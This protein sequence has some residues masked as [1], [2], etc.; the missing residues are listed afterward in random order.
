MPPLSSSDRVRDDRLAPGASPDRRPPST[1]RRDSLRGNQHCGQSNRRARL[2]DIHRLLLDL[3]LEPMTDSDSSDQHLIDAHPDLMPELAE[4]LRKH[5]SIRAALARADEV[6][7]RQALDRLRGDDR[8]H[9]RGVSATDAPASGVT[10]PP[11]RPLPL[12]IG[13]YLLVERIGEGGFATVYRARDSELRR[14]VA[15]KIP[16][17]DRASDPDELAGYLAEARMAA[18]LDHPSIVPVFD[19]G[20]M[21]GGGCYVVSK[22]IPGTDLAARLSKDQLAMEQ[23][24]SIVAEIAEALS[25][26]HA[27]GLIHRD[28]KPA[29]ILLDEQD[30]PFLADFGLALQQRDV[31]EQRSYAGTPVYMSPE[32]ARGEAHRVDAR[33]DVFSLGVVLYEL[34]TATQPFKSDSY[35]QILENVLWSDPPTPSSLCPHLPVDL[36]RI[37]LR[38]IA[39]RAIDRYQTA[40]DFANDLRLCLQTIRGTA[41]AEHAKT[42]RPRLHDHTPIE[43]SG[44]GHVRVVP[45]GLRAFDAGDADFFLDL[46]PGPVD[47]NGLPRAVHHWKQAI[48]STAP[49][50]SFDVGLLY[51]PSGCGKSSLVRAGLLPHLAEHVTTVYVEATPEG[52][53]RTLRHRLSLEAVQ[54][55]ESWDNS[56]SLKDIL[57]RFRRGQV[58]PHHG[59]LLI[60]IDQFEQWLHGRTEEN[61]REL[62]LALRQSDGIR[63][64]CLLLVRDDFWLSVGRFFTALEIDL[65]QGKNAALVDLFDRSH[66]EKVLV[67][68]GRYFGRLPAGREQLGDRQREFVQQAI[69]DL[70]E[71]NRVIPV[72]LA[73]FAEMVKDKSWQ[74]STLRA[75]GGTEGVGVTFLEET[76][77]SQ[78]A[79]PQ[80]RSHQRAVRAVL[81]TLLPIARSS[82]RGSIRSNSE[83]LEASGYA[84]KPEAFSE[85]MRILDRQTRLLTPVDAEDLAEDASFLQP[86]RRYYQLTHDYLV[87]SLRQWLQTKSLTTRQGRARLR[88]GRRA[89]LWMAQ[90]ESRQLPSIVEWIRIRLW[91]SKRSWSH[92]Q[93]RMMRSAVRH[94]AR[95]MGL[96]ALLVLIVVF[97]GVE[98]TGGARRLMMRVRAS[99]APVW[100]ALGMEQTVWNLLEQN[101]D[102]SLR[103][104]V[105]QDL[106]PLVSGPADLLEQLPQQEDAGVRQALVLIAG[107]LAGKP[108]Q[109]SDRSE[110]IRRKDPAIQQLVELLNEDPDPGMHAASWW[111]LQ[112]FEQGKRV[113]QTHSALRSRGVRGNRQWYVNSVGQTMVV[114]P[115]PE[116]FLHGSPPDESRRDADESQHPGW[117]RRSFS[118]AATETTFDQYQ[119]FLRSDR[120]EKRIRTTARGPL[121]GQLPATNVTWFDAAAYCNWLSRT[122]GIA[123][124]Q[125]CYQP[126]KDGTYGP[127]MTTRAEFWKLDGYRLPTEIEWEFACRA[128]TRS[129]WH[130]GND[131]EYLKFY[132]LIRS[133]HGQHVARLKPNGFGLFDTLGNVAEWCQDVYRPNG[134]TADQP[135]ADN[136]TSTVPV[137]ADEPRVTRGGSYADS[138]DDVRSAARGHQR[139]ARQL[140]TVGFRIARSY[141]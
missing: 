69:S 120:R 27:H 137:D 67:D 108:G 39:K 14:D 8:L 91:T 78:T 57:S 114:I 23:S 45:K 103:T 54:T 87:P 20:Y 109:Q 31:C 71:E 89:A 13:R 104:E 58:L 9:R 74:P 32:Q 7:Y 110:E 29:N 81:Q 44:P 118:I 92:E 119:R 61:Q 77:C 48:E 133:G 131:A 21:D 22:L 107:Q 83:L 122:E 93:R 43:E 66:A 126:A 25:H 34:L 19:L 101:G 47:R 97:S 123:L 106:D 134:A 117:I 16:H 128:R 135:L 18:T 113:A 15:I 26:A 100:L 132:A 130:F 40:I 30:R 38:A 42:G 96:L 86:D 84:T 65:V 46:L 139:P 12:Q 124:D 17:E 98:L 28:V 76:F 85:L 138:T 115:G 94:Y 116:R 62:L 141:P 49:G 111:A 136:G 140:E 37:C 55:T 4:E 60:V 127:G 64:Q 88:L 72:R 90:P 80:Y 52:T 75:I 121:A 70:S 102:P 3:E 11:E 112:Q 82:I 79:N 56:D 33:S 36:E 6:E 2:A 10:V 5:R 99:T 105:I 41:G 95:S 129:T 51:G 24:L 53:E 35:D 1:S 73:L 63:V 50:E 125:W 59:K 68:Y